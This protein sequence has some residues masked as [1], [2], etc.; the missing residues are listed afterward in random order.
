MAGSRRICVKV[1][2]AGARA[3][4]P[5]WSAFAD[6][7]G[8]RRFSLYF[9]AYAACA[10][11]DKIEDIPLAFGVYERDGGLH[12]LRSGVRAYSAAFAMSVVRV[13]VR[14]V[15]NSSAAVG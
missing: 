12:T 5:S 8:I 3:L 6:H 1:C 10:D 11:H 4:I 13:R 2:Q 14:S 15:T 7:D 9:N